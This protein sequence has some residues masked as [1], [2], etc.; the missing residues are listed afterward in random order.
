MYNWYAFEWSEF[1]LGNIT[2]S[3]H[4]F[5]AVNMFPIYD[6]YEL[7]FYLHTVSSKVLN[8]T[9]YRSLHEKIRQWITE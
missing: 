4:C 5:V 8:I 7:G 6:I 9:E 1:P 3:L 2:Y